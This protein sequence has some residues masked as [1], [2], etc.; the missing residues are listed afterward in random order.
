MVPSNAVL[1]L[2]L[3]SAIETH[4]YLDTVHSHRAVATSQAVQDSASEALVVALKPL[5]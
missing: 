4:R 3:V 2:C 1:L 5:R